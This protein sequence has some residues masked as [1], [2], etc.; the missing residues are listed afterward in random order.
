MMPSQQAR[1]WGGGGGP[2]RMT[3]DL[4]PASK[5]GVVL[6]S[7]FRLQ[8]AFMGQDEVHGLLFTGTHLIG[9]LGGRGKVSANQWELA[10]QD[11]QLIR[12]VLDAV[13]RRVQITLWVDEEPPHGGPHI[14][15]PATNLQMA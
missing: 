11:S 8:L 4:I 2:S 10:P 7:F 14:A 5:P 9:V 3:I 12:I 6:S 13:L 1:S 15:L